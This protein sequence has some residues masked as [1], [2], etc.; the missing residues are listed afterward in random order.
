MTQ[1]CFQKGFGLRGEVRPV[2]VGSYHS[3]LVARDGHTVI[4]RGGLILFV[5]GH[6]AADLM[7]ATPVAAVAS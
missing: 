4:I 7:A 6:S 2:L 1:I 5:R 3:P